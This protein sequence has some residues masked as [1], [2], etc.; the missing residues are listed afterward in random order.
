MKMVTFTEFRNHASDLF[1][2]V[3]QGET[4]VVL[5]HGRPIAQIIPTGN[6]LP[7]WKATALRLSVKGGDLSSAIMEERRHE[8]VS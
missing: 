4:L 5:R 7:S 2:S 1:T 3:E 8:T 6:K